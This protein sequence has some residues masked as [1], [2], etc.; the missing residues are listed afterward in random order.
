[1]TATI[2]LVTNNE[3][4]HKLDLEDIICFS[5][6]LMDYLV[7]YLFDEDD[8]LWED[9][10]EESREL[11]EIALRESGYI[12][13][14]VEDDDDLATKFFHKDSSGINSFNLSDYEEVM[15]LLDSPRTYIR[16]GV[17]AAVAYME[18]AGS[19]SLQDFQSSYCG[20]FDNDEE[21]ARNCLSDLVEIPDEI[22]P[23][24]DWEKYASDMM[25]N[26]YE[27]SG[28]YFSCA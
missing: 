16:G 2:T 26:Y 18:W 11:R 17:E 15:D 24:F 9:L 23:Y 8:G 19:W 3:G 27:Q 28:F 12:I 14:D 1:M 21:F 10:P 7:Y 22:E 6:N 25:S 4:R 5:S 20:Q 13:E